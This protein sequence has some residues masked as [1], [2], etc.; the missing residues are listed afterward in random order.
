MKQKRVIAL[1][2]FLLLFFAA[3]V[4]L[5]GGGFRSERSLFHG[6]EAKVPQRPSPAEGGNTNPSRAAKVSPTVAVDYSRRPPGFTALAMITKFRMDRGARASFVLMDP[7]GNVTERAIAYFSL[8]EKELPL[9]RKACEELRVS[10]R[11]LMAANITRLPSP[12]GDPTIRSYKLAA[13]PYESEG[14]FAAFLDHL[15][16]AVGPERAWEM[17]KTMETT[18]VAAAYGQIEMTF[19]VIDRIPSNRERVLTRI[20]YNL[21]NP[22]TGKRFGSGLSPRETVGDIYFGVMDDL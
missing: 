10:T 14:V 9:V 8:D 16:A 6:R 22:A 19:K 5:P 21:V 15:T 7:K 1:V 3:V 18:Y 11:K 4:A 12:D 17:A 20:S 2:I 13:F